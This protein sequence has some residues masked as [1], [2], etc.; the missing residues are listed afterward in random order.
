[1]KLSLIIL[2]NLIVLNTSP[3]AKEDSIVIF[4]HG[5]A[6][7]PKV[8]EY[9]KKVKKIFKENKQNFTVANIPP[10]IDLAKHDLVLAEEI[11]RISNG[12]SFH[13]VAHSMGGILARKVLKDFNLHKKC[14]SLTTI[15]TPHRGSVVANWAMKKMKYQNLSKIEKIIIKLVVGDS[16][17]AIPTLTTH[18]MKYYFNPRYPN[19]KN[20]KYY[21]LGFYIPHKV[22]DYT[23]N[24]IIKYVHNIQR[25]KYFILRNDGFVSTR[26]AR[27]G[28]YLGTS[29]GDHFSE[30]APFK[31]NGERIYKKVFKQVS[32]NI[33]QNFQL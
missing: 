15:S 16:S 5:L 12:K 4:V 21:S 13:L 8:Y 28:K 18:Y 17:D 27:W 32:S 26:S 31:F 23:K 20:I 22:E 19:Y 7:S 3:Y 24:P 29:K 9:N 2:L 33:H 6:A 10:M 11:K 14:L 1:M 30:T 25:S